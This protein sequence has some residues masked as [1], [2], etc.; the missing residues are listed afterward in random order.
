MTTLADIRSRVRKDLHDTDAATYRWTD[1]QLDRHVDRALN[2]LSL[3]V[4]VEKTATVA[5]TN[6][7][8]DLSLSALGGLIAVEAVEY[9][10]G[11]FPAAYAAFGRWAETLTI[12]VEPVPSG[13]NAK[14]YYTARHT[15]DGSGSTVPAHLEDLL[16]TGA[17]GYAALDLSSFTTDRVTTAPDVAERYAA[18][19][20]AWLSAFRE[21]LR[22]HGRANRVR[23]RRLYVAV[24]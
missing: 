3:A 2:D 6:G 5:T 13:G 23:A 17:A 21:L 20:R 22:Q 11:E 8:R 4:P 10:P 24:S 14:L 1:S 19:G 18:W 7:S 9:P 15:L 12:H 16:A